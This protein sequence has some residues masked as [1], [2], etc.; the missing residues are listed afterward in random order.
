[1]SVRPKPPL[2]P[3]AIVSLTKQAV[4]EQ[5]ATSAT[6]EGVTYFRIRSGHLVCA[7]CDG[8]LVR[9]TAVWTPRVSYWVLDHAMHCFPTGT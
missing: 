7:K 9:H 8:E 2:S 1:M 3:A 5:R 4:Q 6:E